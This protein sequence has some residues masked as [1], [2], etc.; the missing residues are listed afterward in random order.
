M[1]SQSIIYSIYVICGHLYSRSTGVALFSSSLDNSTTSSAR[2]RFSLFFYFLVYFS[3]S[4]WWA[5]ARLAYCQIN[6]SYYSVL[7]QRVFSHNPCPSD[8]WR[9]MLSLA[10]LNISFEPRCTRSLA[11]LKISSEPRCTRSL[12]KLKI[13]FEPRCTRS[14]NWPAD[15]LGPIWLHWQGMPPMVQ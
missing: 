7:L 8:I 5:E 4:W 1:C 9:M 15:T 13:S 11:K 3:L 12:A 10:K 14:P 6:E 2:E